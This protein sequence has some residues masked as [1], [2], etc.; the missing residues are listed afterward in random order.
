MRIVEKRWRSMCKSVEL[1]KCLVWQKSICKNEITE[2]NTGCRAEGHW[3]IKVLFGSVWITNSHP[4]WDTMAERGWMFRWIMHV[5]CFADNTK[6]VRP[7]LRKDSEYV[8]VDSEN[9]RWLPHKPCT[10]WHG[11]WLVYVICFLSVFCNFEPVVTTW[12]P[13]I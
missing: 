6:E 4:V 1:I 2:E 13:W 8:K 11:F 7:V 10:V 3:E 9:R 5:R 12:F